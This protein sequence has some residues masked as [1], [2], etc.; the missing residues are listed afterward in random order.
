LYVRSVRQS[1]QCKYLL[2][3]QFYW[4]ANIFKT[5]YIPSFVSKP[6]H[7]LKDFGTVAARVLFLQPRGAEDCLYYIC[8]A[9]VWPLTKE[10]LFRKASRRTCMSLAFW[11]TSALRHFRRFGR[12]SEHSTWTLSIMK[13]QRQQGHGRDSTENSLLLLLLPLPPRQTNTLVGEELTLHLIKRDLVAMR[14]KVEWG[15]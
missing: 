3:R 4:M 11:R 9:G 14:G 10:Q 6:L 15:S 7:Y 12:N 1:S 2:I 5:I 8:R 13:G